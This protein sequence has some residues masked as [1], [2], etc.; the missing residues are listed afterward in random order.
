MGYPNPNES[1]YLVIEIEKKATNE[2]GESGWDYKN[3]REY[4]KLQN[5]E[6]N[7]H[8]LAGIPFTVSLSELMKTKIK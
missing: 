4:K 7:P 8:I 6:K 1:E 5:I 2:L 3:L